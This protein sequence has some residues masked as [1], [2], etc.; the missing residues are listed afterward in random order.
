MTVIDGIELDE[1]NIRMNDIKL[2]LNNNYPIEDKLNVITVISNPCGYS[3]RYR[4]LNEFVNRMKLEENV[5]LFIVELAYKDQKFV[6]TQNNNKNH[7][8]LRTEIPLWHKENL[9]NVDGSNALFQIYTLNVLCTQQLQHK[10]I[11]LLIIFYFFWLCVRLTMV[12][13]V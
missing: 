10:S 4:L 9:I 5:N 2:A 11:I 7:L 1:I 12:T 13:F 3:T 6:V 8:Q